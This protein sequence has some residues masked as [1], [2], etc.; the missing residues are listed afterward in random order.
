MKTE[1]QLSRSDPC[2]KV[3]RVLEAYGLEQFD[4]SLEQQWTGTDSASIREL[5]RELNRELIR[6]ALTDAG[7]IPIDGEAENLR[8]LLR[9]SEVSESRKIEARRRLQEEGVDTESLLDDFV[10]HQTV[11]NHLRDCRGISRSEPQSDED[12]LSVAK[13]TIFGLQNRT[14]VVT[15]KTLAQ[16]GTN[17]LLAPP[18][19]DV[20]VDVQAIC[21][22]C[23]RSNDIEGLL[24]TGRCQCQA[25]DS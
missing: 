18:E 23:G 2:C 22:Q 25:D 24:E 9:S 19:F 1:D 20:V 11:H 6:S 12:R 5:T 10:S 7:S 13:S 16:L 15:E 8:R 21:E 14:E 3:G 4:T 17:D